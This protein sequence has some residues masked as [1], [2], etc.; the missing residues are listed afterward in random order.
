[1]S[2]RLRTLLEVHDVVDWPRVP[3]G[4]VHHYY[5]TDRANVSLG[6]REDA[7]GPRSENWIRFD[8]ANFTS[9]Q[10][11]LV[12]TGTEP[13]TT[14][15]VDSC[16]TDGVCDSRESQGASGPA[17][18]PVRGRDPADS[19]RDGST[20]PA[21]ASTAR[22]RLFAEL[23]VSE[24]ELLQLV[25]NG[26]FVAGVKRLKAAAGS[27]LSASVTDTPMVVEV[28]SAAVAPI[29]V[30]APEATEVERNPFESEGGSIPSDAPV[31]PVAGVEEDL[32][33]YEW[34]G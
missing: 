14:S 27:G 13:V 15:D 18:A 2:A 1:M 21:E 30:G 11:E 3:Y 33:V 5:R 8:S 31:A 4:Q 22:R 16:V 29:E 32:A 17:E 26:E 12:Q 28:S 20:L 23:G 34:P 9:L 25:S 10:P 24:N 6:R 19:A 7:E